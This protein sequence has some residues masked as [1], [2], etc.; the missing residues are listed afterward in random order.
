MY[1]RL[2]CVPTPGWPRFAKFRISKKRE[3]PKKE[4]KNL[5]LSKVVDATLPNGK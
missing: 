3:K 4:K 1:V 2:L 5:V